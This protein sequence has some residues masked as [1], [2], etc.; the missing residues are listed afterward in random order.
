MMED[1]KQCPF[2]GETIKAKAQ[3]CKFCGKWLNE[4]SSEPTVAETPK[5]KICP[6][7]G[8]EILDVAKK[9]KFCGEVL[10]GSA[11]LNTYRRPYKPLPYELQRFNWG[12]FGF[13]WLWG[14]FNNSY[15]TFWYMA[16]VLLMFVP[17]VGYFAPLGFAIW[18]GI[19]GNE[20]AWNNKNWD[21]VEHFN[22]V[23]I[24]WAKAAIC[25][26]VWIV[27]TSIFIIITL[28]VWSLYFASLFTNL[29]D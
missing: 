4:E 27:I 8:E 3:K 26:A 16:S 7:C 21:S 25:L 23:Q 9:C 11:N 10:D 6:A 15:L 12:A 28:V 19:K 17:Y 24:N 20:W 22:S 5:T 29:Y 1:T 13:T 14:I 18:F 2:C